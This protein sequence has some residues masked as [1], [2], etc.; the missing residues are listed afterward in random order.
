[1]SAVL[2]NALEREILS[3]IPLARA[4]ELRVDRT[5]GDRIVLAAPLGPNIN[6]KGCAFGGSLASVLTLSGWALI[7][8]RLREAG[9]DCDVYVQD[10]QLRYLAPVWG[11]IRAEARVADGD[12]WDSFLGM[13]NARGKGRLR[14]VAVVADAN[15]QPATTLEA[16]FVALRREPAVQAARAGVG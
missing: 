1:M 12:S 11:E 2:V 3:E 14:V 8:L 5:A 13:I 16:R 9:H 4:M 7:V 15:G 10:S 6:D